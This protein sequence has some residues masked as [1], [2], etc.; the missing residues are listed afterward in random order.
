LHLINKLYTAMT[1]KTIRNWMNLAFIIAALVG[2][3]WFYAKN[4]ETGTYII[5]CAMMV[6]FV[7]SGLR[8]MQHE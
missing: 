3:Y 7:E 8:M 2:M 5:L 1:L 6:K 4:R